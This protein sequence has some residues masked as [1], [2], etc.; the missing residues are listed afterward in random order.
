MKKTIL[1]VFLILFAGIGMLTLSGCEEESIIDRGIYGTS[2]TYTYRSKGGLQVGYLD[3]GNYF[4]QYYKLPEVP[5]IIITS[6]KDHADLFIEGFTTRDGK[7]QMSNINIAD[8]K[9]TPSEEGTILSEVRGYT[10][11]S[12]SLTI[13]GEAQPIR[14][15]KLGELKASTNRVAL[16]ELRI[17]FGTDG[18]DCVRLTNITGVVAK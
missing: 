8:L 17:I 6:N 7:R 12:G 5:N 14:Q 11:L 13:D 10:S 15:I 3:G 9:M 1:A 2:E 16:T 18:A 4:N